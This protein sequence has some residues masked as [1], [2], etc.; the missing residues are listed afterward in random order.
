MAPTPW[1]RAG[2]VCL[3]RRHRVRVRPAPDPLVRHP[4]GHRDPGGLLA[5]PPARGPGGLAG[6]PA[7]AG[8]AVGRGGGPGRRAP[9]RGGLQLGLLRPVPGEDHRGLGGR[10]RDARRAHRGPARRRV[11]RA[12]VGRA[13]APRARRHRAQHDPGPGDRPLGE[14]LQRGSLRG[15]HRSAVEALHLTEPPADRVPAGRLLPPHVPL[16]VAVEPAGVRA[17]GALDPP[18]GRA[19]S[20]RGLLRLHRALLGGPVLH[21]GGAARQLLDRALPG[22]TAR[23]RGGRAGGGGGDP[24]GPAAAPDRGGAGRGRVGYG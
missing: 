11:A 2:R 23:E 14:L 24:V 16:R 17:A 19:V 20:R 10:A 4:H 22:R 13:G 15:A 3:S 5:R 7:R 18:A 8:R 1:Y 21:R 6:R 9:V 12:A